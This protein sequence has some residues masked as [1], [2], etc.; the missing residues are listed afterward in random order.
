MVNQEE[1]IA[2]GILELYAAGA[3]SPAEQQEVEQVAAASPEVRYALDEALV[4]MEGYARA[5]AVTPNPALKNR[6]IQ[7]IEDQQLE[8]EAM[9]AEVRPLYGEQESSPYKWMFAAS[10]TLFLLSGVLSFY[11][12]S[13]WQ[14]AENRLAQAEAQEQL[15]AQNFNTVSQRV[16][17]QERLVRLLRDE[18]YRPVKL[19]GVEAH[20]EANAI[21]Y[22]NPSQQ[23]V[24]IDQGQLPAPPA[25]RQ[26]QLW[27]LLD[28]KPIDAGMLQQDAQANLQQM[29]QV[30]AAQAF[31]ITLEP[32]GGSVN[33]TMEQLY[34]LG[35][36][37][38]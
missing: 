25:G 6:I 24:F 17:Q 37:Q 22:W 1:Y 21:V 31:A 35:E 33:P 16:A 32:E 15:L 3:L 11:F 4:A 5:H 8:R 2:S 27:A 29:K 9:A 38:S 20:P 7:Q 10:I 18:N 12:Y 30:G 14:T 28:G 23:N 13:R 26:Y 19:Q 34:V 36:V